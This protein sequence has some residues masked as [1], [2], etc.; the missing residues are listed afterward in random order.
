VEMKKRG[1]RRA[2]DGIAML[3]SGK[4]S[5]FWKAEA[6]AIYIDAGDG[7]R[8]LVST[9]STALLSPLGWGMSCAMGS[10]VE[11]VCTFA[12]VGKT[13]LGWGR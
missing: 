12:R 3:S 8:R 4:S 10:L 7:G 1:A 2:D 9:T 13:E 5:L 6:G 11:S